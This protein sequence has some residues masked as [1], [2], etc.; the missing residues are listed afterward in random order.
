MARALKWRGPHKVHKVLFLGG[1][2]GEP[3]GPVVDV[4]RID[5]ARVEVQG[6]CVILR[7][8]AG[9]PHVPV[10]T[11]IVQSPTIPTTATRSR[12]EHANEPLPAS[13]ESAHMVRTRH[14]TSGRMEVFGFLVWLT[15]GQFALMLF[16]EAGI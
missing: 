9:Q 5:V 3:V 10:R 13:T 15:P 16:F 7:T 12:E 14:R 4:L 1:P 6:A 2:H 11:D 8:G